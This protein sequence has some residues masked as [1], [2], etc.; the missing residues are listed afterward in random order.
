MQAESVS[1]VYH[2][3][4]L[5]VRRRCNTDEALPDPT[6]LPKEFDYRLV[7]FR[8]RIP[9]VTI[10]TLATLVTQGLSH[11]AL[12]NPLN[13]VANQPQIK[14]AGDLVLPQTTEKV[15]SQKATVERTGST[16]AKPVAGAIAL[17]ESVVVQEFTPEALRGS[18]SPIA[19]PD[20]D[21]Q[22]VVVQ[23]VLSV[24]PQAT[25]I[26]IAAPETEV[27]LA[28]KSTPKERTMSVKEF[29][30]PGRV[31][32]TMLAEVQSHKAS[33][34]Q[35]IPS[36][37]E[38]AIRIEKPYTSPPQET[39]SL[40][41][42]PVVEPQS[43]PVAT[44]P[45]LE[46]EGLQ[47]QL[48]ALEEPKDIEEF[49]ASPS[50]SIAIPTAFGADNNTGF[51]SATYQKRTRYSSVDDGAL[52]FGIGLGD[53]RK[54]VGIELSYAIASFGSNR[55]FGSGGF[56]IKVHR[57]LPN[58]FAV[59]AG[60]NGFLNLGNR[61]DFEHSLYGVVTKVFRTRDDITLPFS[62]VAI[63]AGIGNGQFRTEEAVDDDRHNI[64]VFGNI[65]VRVA[66]PISL[67]AEWS[68]QDLGIGLSIAP[69][70]NIPLVITPAVRDITGA[71]D[72]TRFVLGTGLAFKF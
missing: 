12:A 43:V 41:Q 40:Q 58:D 16:L 65:A 35:E 50:L 49:Q 53:A 39:V 68:G 32:A 27:T 62:R 34:L 21:A 9:N 72:G 4:L 47:S 64:N 42:T 28:Q 17:P 52:G 70:K 2:R 31:S 60:W 63:T 29:I 57:Q 67:I 26:G 19:L 71:G 10:Y 51:I 36:L 48:R 24:V 69:F 3:N 8:Q 13:G 18:E 56:N 20:R 7:S 1:N 55:D 30:A 45:C 6:D 66:Q 44:K 61:N 11:Q 33:D 25:N 23:T 37:E 14:E 54:S 38:T 22:K 59:A 46:V 15:T 5:S